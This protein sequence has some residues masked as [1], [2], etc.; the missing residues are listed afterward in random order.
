MKMQFI[1]LI[2]ISTL[3]FA[4][5]KPAIKPTNV[6]SNNTNPNSVNPAAAIKKDIPFYTYEIVKTYKHDPKAFTEGLFFYKGFLYEM[7]NLLLEK[8]KLKVVKYCKTTT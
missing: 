5:E 1:L 7:V 2:L 3:A 6:M 4:C 8:L